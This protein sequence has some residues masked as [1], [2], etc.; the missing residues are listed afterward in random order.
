MLSIGSHLSPPCSGVFVDRPVIGRLRALPEPLLGES[1]AR[2]L[3]Y[4]DPSFLIRP[5]CGDARV[6][7]AMLRRLLTEIAV[8]RVESA[9]SLAGDRRSRGRESWTV[10]DPG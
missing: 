3:H 6:R 10:T 8:H 9:R 2:S 1:H 7:G 4:R 5:R